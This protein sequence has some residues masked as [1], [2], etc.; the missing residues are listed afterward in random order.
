MPYWGKNLTASAMDIPYAVLLNHFTNIGIALALG[1]LVGSERGWRGR[2]LEQGDRAAGVRTF[3][4]VALLGGLVASGA[5][6]LTPVQAWLLCAA[7]FAPL[8]LL[9]IAAYWQ[10]SRRDG[11]V[12]LTTEV[13]A[14]VTYWLGVLPAFGLALPAAGTAVIL[15]LLLHLKDTLHYWLR[16]LDR[17]EMTG[18][19]QFL[20]V[21]VVMLP[22]LPDS[23]FG[24]WDALN[25]YQLWWM[26]VL[27]SGLSLVGYFA[28][29][30][31]G[32]NNGVLATSLT[33]GLVS[34]TAVTLSLS[35][36][37][38]DIGNAPV[39][40][41]GILLACGTM[42]ARVIVVVAVIRQDLVVPMLA[43]MA[44]GVITLLAIALLIWRRGGD[45]AGGAAPEVRN[46]FQLVPAL[47]FGALL[48]LVMLGAEAL[49][50]WF[51]DA[52]LY[53]LSLF[54]GLADVD[55]IVLSLSPK[56]GEDL[57][58]DMVILCVAIAGATN[59]LMKGMYCRLIAG[60]ALGWRV[61]LPTLA[62]AAL[63]LAVAGIQVWLL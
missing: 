19:L 51:G 44:T 2:E 34:S 47:Q 41:A 29:R 42:F 57:T 38:R 15:A 8:A 27:I 30:V 39:I 58:V 18:T 20:L 59:T 3:S 48:A 45:D 25:P 23:D 52:G 36:M 24:P 7:V 37:Y 6:S 40:A 53:L 12:G 21:S 22:L 56:A 62:T 26:V 1:L 31:A 54:T 4:L 50:H 49:Q 33:G 14:M 10:L 13:A 28:T 17:Q 46:P 43:P 35:R 60:P 55:A 32:T 5:S 63:V 61:V 11:D 9:L 16:A